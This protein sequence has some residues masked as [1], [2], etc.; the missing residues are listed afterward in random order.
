MTLPLAVS[1]QIVIAVA[2]SAAVV[3][4]VLLFRAEDRYNAEE[5]ARRGGTEPHRPPEPPL[6]QPRR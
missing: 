2:V 3:I 1:G 5:R 4:L 6:G